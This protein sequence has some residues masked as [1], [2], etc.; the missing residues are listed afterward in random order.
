[1]QVWKLW[2]PII[3]EGCSKRME[4]PMICWPWHKKERDFPA[5]MDRSLSTPLPSQLVD[6][7]RR[8]LWQPLDQCPIAAQAVNFKGRY[9]VGTWVVH[10]QENS[11]GNHN[12]ILLTIYIK[13]SWSV[14][15]LLY[16]Y[17]N[18][19]AL[20]SCLLLIYH[21]STSRPPCHVHVPWHHTL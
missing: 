20:S 21:A 7:V 19:H 16:T 18:V 12:S 9:L 14:V 3:A 4:M 8:V 17:P 11:T 6:C 1:M 2:S 13:S 15:R 5:K 10:S